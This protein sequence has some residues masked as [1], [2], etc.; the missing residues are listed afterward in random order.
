MF[1]KKSYGKHHKNTSLHY[2]FLDFGVSI[3]WIS[4]G[5][6]IKYL[7]FGGIMIKLNKINGKEFYLN[8]AQIESIE[9]T[10]DTV[11]HLISE[12]KIIVSES[13]AEI[14]RLIGAK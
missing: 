3:N 14:I 1:F 12:R 9:E 5:L 6:G 10:P 7:T 8:E 11:I 2:L 13:A 4:Q